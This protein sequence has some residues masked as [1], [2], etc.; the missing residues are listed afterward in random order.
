MAHQWRMITG[1]KD[2]DVAQLMRK[3]QIDILVDLAGHT[4]DNRLL[5]FARKPAPI[6]VTYLGYPGSSGLSTMD[7]RISDNFADPPGMT[8][9]L[10]TEKLVRLPHGFLCYRPPASAPDVGPLSADKTGFITFGSF[11]HLAKITHFTVKMW[12]KILKQIPNS[13]LLIKSQGLNDPAWRKALS[14]RFAAQ[15]IGEDRLEMLAK[16]P[17][18]GNHLQLYHRIDIALDPFP[19]HGTTTT[20]EAM[21]MG[22]PVISLAGKTH[23]SRV[24]VSLLSNTGL[25]ELIAQSPEEY[26]QIAT[27]L[28]GD[29]PRLRELHANLR[30]RLAASPLL[31]AKT[32]ARDIEAAYR[33]MW[34]DYC[35]N[36]SE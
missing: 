26:V 2:A 13:R 18:L 7:Y 30:P 31:D 29:L 9:S 25:T 11:N 20:L 10:H 23:A 12:A 21:W 5:V 33:Q 1:M 3:D 27:K 4:S 8:E 6:Q 16:I 28:A 24:G 34:R 17:S 22:V 19:Y 14:D 32:F 36:G 15:G 35:R